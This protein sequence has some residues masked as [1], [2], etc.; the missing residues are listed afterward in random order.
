MSSCTRVLKGAPPTHVREGTL[1]A[2]PSTLPRRPPA[3]RLTHGPL[4]ARLRPTLPLTLP[5][6]GN[7]KEWAIPLASEGKGQEG[8]A[9]EPLGWARPPADVR[10]PAC[11]RTGSR[12]PRRTPA[13]RSSTFYSPER[14]LIVCSTLHNTG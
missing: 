2:H 10:P 13:G 14:R 5:Q 7:R 6:A 12:T 4:R 8:P 3:C 9:S 11:P 1:H